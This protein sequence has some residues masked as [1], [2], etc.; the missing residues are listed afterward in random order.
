MLG[1]DLE[2]IDAIAAA[3]AQAPLPVFVLAQLLQKDWDWH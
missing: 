3:G 2:T 1:L